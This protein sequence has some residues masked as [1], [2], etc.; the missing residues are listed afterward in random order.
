ME[1]MQLLRQATE[2]FLRTTEMG[3]M[4]D[5]SSLS[6][7]DFCTPSPCWRRTIRLKSPSRLWL[8]NFFPSLRHPNLKFLGERFL[9][10]L[11]SL[12]YCASTEHF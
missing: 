10:S 5:M 4:N 3:L 8:L 9:L 12:C 11:R 6:C 1:L 2:G 7:S